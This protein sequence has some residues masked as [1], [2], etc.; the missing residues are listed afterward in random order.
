[1]STVP[2]ASAID[3]PSSRVGIAGMGRMGSAMAA[4][5]VDAG[6]Q[7]HGWNRDPDRVRRAG[8]T[9]AATPRLLAEACPVVI[10]SIFDAE[11]IE[12]VFG[13][14]DGL[15]SAAEGV[16]FIEMSTVAPRT[17]RDLASRV[18]DAGGRFIEC[19]V[20]GTVAPARNGQ[21][22]GFAGGRAEDVTAA[23]SVLAHLCRR[24]VHVG[25]VGAG[26]RTKL[27]VNLPL[28]AFWQALGEAIAMMH[29]VGGDARWLIDLFADTPGAPAV[30][31]H[32]SDAIVEALGGDGPAGAAFPIDA[33]RKDLGLALADVAYDFPMPLTT[34][35]LA[36]LDEA[37][38]AGWGERDCAWQPAFWARKADAEA[39]A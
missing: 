11:A 14:P 16:L 36:A 17:Q 3:P 10:T 25:V 26:A 7:V 21:L 22:L 12:A 13:A 18:V 5:L 39:L 29:G 35:V 1:M 37:A 24:V 8:L 28:I 20:S 32:K 34:S 30:M 15:L 27:A 19:P 9:S 23:R 38:L 4:R 33:M 2:N 6:C 31:K